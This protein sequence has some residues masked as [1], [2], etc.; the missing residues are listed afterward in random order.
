MKNLELIKKL[1]IFFYRSCRLRQL[2]SI[3][4]K[5]FGSFLCKME[6][7][8]IQI[9]QKRFIIETAQRGSDL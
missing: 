7:G 2:F 8:F 1:Q 6:V 4:L 3:L 5:K 9:F